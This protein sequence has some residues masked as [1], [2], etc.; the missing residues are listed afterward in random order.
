VL[1]QLHSGELMLY[2]PGGQLQPLHSADCFP[3]GCQQMAALP[4]ASL[5]ATG[6]PA[7]GLNANGQLYWGSRLLASEVTSF[8]VRNRKL[9]RFCAAVG[10]CCD[11]VLGPICTL[12]P[13]LQARRVC[14]IFL[15]IVCGHMCRSGLIRV[16]CLTHSLTRSSSASAGS[17][18]R[19][20]RCL[21]A[22][23]HT[24]AHAAHAAC[25]RLGSQRRGPVGAA[26]AGYSAGGCA[27]AAAAAATEL[28]RCNEG[29]HASCCS[30]QGVSDCRRGDCA[31]HR[32]AWHAGGS[33]AG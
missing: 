11:F 1:L 3:R 33:T 25:V 29:C 26:A 22:L 28:P 5:A 31:Q 18:Q 14:L 6:S 32:A 30:C 7:V 24:A 27:T 16:P 21:P 20:R 17:Q 23:H 9:C 19:S 13:F 10:M 4:P 2:S 12:A 15:V 8:A